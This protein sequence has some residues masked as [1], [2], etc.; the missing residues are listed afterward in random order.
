MLLAGGEFLVQLR[1]LL[2]FFGTLSLQVLVD[3]LQFMELTLHRS[4]LLL[5]RTEVLLEVDFNNISQL[6]ISLSPL[7]LGLIVHL[8]WVKDVVN[9]GPV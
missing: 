1:Y 8:P 4:F 7:L 5:S 9:L 2:V 3:V 6:L